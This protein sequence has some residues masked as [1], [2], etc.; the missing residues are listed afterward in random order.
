[1]DNCP[2][3]NSN[4]IGGEIPENIKHHYGSTTHWKREIGIDGGF[5]GIYDGIVAIR[6]PDCKEDF[7]RNNSPWGLEMF[8][9]YKEL[10]NEAK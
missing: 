4:W 6:C 5:L 9:K 1:M 7:P 2:K 3:C 8:K 10:C